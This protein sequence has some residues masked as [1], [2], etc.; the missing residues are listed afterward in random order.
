M[1]SHQHSITAILIQIKTES[2][3]K[4][5]PYLLTPE[6]TCLQVINLPLGTNVYFISV[7][8]V[9]DVHAV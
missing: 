8:E 3:A 7:F 9:E 6:A 4:N 1:H 5:K 2:S